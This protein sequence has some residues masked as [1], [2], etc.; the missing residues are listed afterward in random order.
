MTDKALFRDQAC[1]QFFHNICDVIRE[2]GICLLFWGK[3]SKKIK[4]DVN[5]TGLSMVLH[6]LAFPLCYTTNLIPLLLHYI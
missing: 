1:L 3:E 5:D 2:Q 4:S 6:H